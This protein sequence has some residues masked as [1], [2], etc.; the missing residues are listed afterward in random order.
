MQ[1]AT[2]NTTAL[3]YVNKQG[4]TH[5]PSL[6]Y[7]AVDLWKWC[8]S[9]HVFPIVVHL[10]MDNNTLADH[11]SQLPTRTHE[12]TLNDAIFHRLCKRWGTPSVDLFASD[13]NNK[14]TQFCSRAG[15]DSTSLG[16]AFLMNWSQ[17]L[18]YMFPPLS[19]SEGDRSPPA[20]RSQCN[21]DSPVLAPPAMAHSPG[22]D[23]IGHAPPPSPH[24]SPLA[25]PRPR[26]SPQRRL[27]QFHS[28]E[29]TPKVMQVLLRACKTSTTLLYRNKWKSFLKYTHDNGL[30]AVPISLKTL[31]TYLFHLFKFGLSQST[32]WVYLSAVMA[33]QPDDFPSSKLFSHPMVKKFLKGLNNIR[34]SQQ[35]I[36]PQWSLQLVLNTLMQPPFEPM[37][38]I[39]FKFLTLKS[40]FLV[41]STSAK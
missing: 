25:R 12:W 38:S 5:S 21:P 22:L 4:G 40:V 37:A 34:P 9:N 16:D 39:D 18:L 7:L 23:V 33:H 31:L 32:L 41:A 27:S 26:P 1:L 28:L 30:P 20:R 24:R 6:L 8:Y 10:S 11:L 14:C 15:R 29:D 19:H 36:T 2:D 13:A 3:F 35:R 17:G